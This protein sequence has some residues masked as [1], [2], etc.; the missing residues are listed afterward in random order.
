MTMTAIE[1]TLLWFWQGALST[2][3]S[4]ITLSSASD[5]A[6]WVGYA[7]Q[8]GTI[9]KV[10]FRTG[11]VTTSATLDVRLETIGTD[12]NPSGSL[13]ATNTNGSQASLAANTWYEVTLTA[14]A[15]VTKGD[16]IALVIV[17]PAVSPGNLEVQR[18]SVSRSIFPY[19][20]RFAASAWTRSASP[21]AGWLHYTTGTA[22]PSVVGMKPATDS[23][24]QY[25]NSS[26][27]D[28]RGN[29]ITMPFACKVQGIWMINLTTSDTGDFDAVLY[30]SNSG[31]LESVSMDGDLTSTTNSGQVPFECYFDTEVTLSYGQVVRVV[32]KPTS[33]TNTRL[34]HI[35]LNSTSQLTAAPGIGNQQLSTRTD[36]GAWSD[37]NT[38]VA[39]IGLILTGIDDGA[40]RALAYVG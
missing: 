35:A 37:D 7:P 15:S 34:P 28:E 31:T 30:D 38:R 10:A 21:W 4:V 26:T 20:A 22:Y 25:N 36:A 9:D 2:S 24:A 32:K 33:A 6:A 18:Y 8:T 5:K 16:K 11:A 27:P 40:G 17:N 1:P 12:G 29:K 19:T 3:S 39:S 14:G 13:W 23:S